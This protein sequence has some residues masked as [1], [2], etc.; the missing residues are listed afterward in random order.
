MRACLMDEVLAIDLRALV[1][2]FKVRHF[3]ELDLWNRLSY[4]GFGNSWMIPTVAGKL[5]APVLERLGLKRPF[6]KTRLRERRNASG[7]M[8]FN[9]YTNIHFS[10]SKRVETGP[11]VLKPLKR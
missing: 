9:R 7:V 8:R 4:S 6:E 10:E 3:R 5:A 2:F 11:T 1:G